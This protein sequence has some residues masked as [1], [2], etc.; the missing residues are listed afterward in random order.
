MVGNKRP[1]EFVHIELSPYSNYSVLSKQKYQELLNIGIDGVIDGGSNFTIRQ[2][3]LLALAYLACSLRS[4]KLLTITTHREVDFSWS[5]DAHGDPK[6]FDFNYFYELLGSFLGV[7]NVTFGIQTDRAYYHNQVNLDGYVNEFWP[8][9]KKKPG[10]LA[11]NQ[12]GTPQRYPGNPAHLY[13]N[14]R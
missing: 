13:V 2:Y 1:E 6:D 11:A 4:G 7:S 5:S 12:Y 3:D 14:E 9:V 10:V 8:F